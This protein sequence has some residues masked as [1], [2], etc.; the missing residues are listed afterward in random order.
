MIGGD[1]VTHSEIIAINIIDI[2]EN[3]LDQHNIQIPDDDRCGDEEEAPIYGCTYFNLES[4]I[5][6]IL[7][8]SGLIIVPVKFD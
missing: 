2:F 7:I 5:A 1:Y 4:E 3:L 6:Q 8:D